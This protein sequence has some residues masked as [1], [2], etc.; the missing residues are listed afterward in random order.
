MHT[1]FNSAVLLDDLV[2]EFSIVS[3]SGEDE[4]RRATKPDGIIA[5]IARARG[6]LASEDRIRRARL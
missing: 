4:V 5:E 1:N 6:I 3:G 2:L